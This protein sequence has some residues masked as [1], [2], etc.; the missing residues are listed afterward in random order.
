MML[1][2]IIIDR[3]HK[4]YYN[5]RTDLYVNKFDEEILKIANE[6]TKISENNKWSSF[7]YAKREF[8]CCSRRM[9]TSPSKETRMFV[10]I[11]GK[12][13]VF[14]SLLSFVFKRK[15]KSL[16]RISKKLLCHTVSKYFWGENFLWKLYWLSAFIFCL[17][18]L[19][20]YKL[21]YMLRIARDWKRDI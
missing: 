4:S 12:T 20:V 1:K 21:L 18:V 17:R 2:C 8:I 11:N 15:Q 6:I 13:K 14:K 19:F 3:T 16:D 10:K 9:R 5:D 7:V